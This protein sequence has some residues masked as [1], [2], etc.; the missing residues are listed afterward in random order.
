MDSI[1]LTAELI[2][3]NAHAGQFRRDGV[4]PYIT[5]PEAVAILLCDEGPEVVATAWLH[6]VL[7]D[8][9]VK[10]RHLREQGLPESVVSAVITLTKWGTDYDAYLREI[11]DNPIAC[12]VK[13]ADMLHN[14]SSSPTRK[15]IERYTE[16]VIYLS[17]A[18]NADADKL[19]LSAM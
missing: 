2:A 16:G 1:E 6:D 19:P 8:T 11:K 12:R 14:L 5:H 9:D 4:T 18:H 17:S 7:E 3:T 10:P 13:I 15:Q